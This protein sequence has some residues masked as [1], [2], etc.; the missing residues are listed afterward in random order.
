MLISSRKVLS[1]LLRLT[2]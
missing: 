1:W 2:A